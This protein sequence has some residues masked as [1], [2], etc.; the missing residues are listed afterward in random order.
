MIVSSRLG[1]NHLD[2]KYEITEVREFH[3]DAVVSEYR[4]HRVH[5][6]RLE[7][8]LPILVAVPLVE[9]VAP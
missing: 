8:E 1:I 5:R 9:L 6:D 4:L 7:L 2:E 3:L